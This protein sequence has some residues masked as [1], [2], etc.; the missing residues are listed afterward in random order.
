MILKNGPKDGKQRKEANK[1]G[2]WLQTSIVRY[3]V[4]I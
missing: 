3:D 1:Q 4:E 2:V